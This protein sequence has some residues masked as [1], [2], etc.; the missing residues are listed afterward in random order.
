M[1]TLTVENPNTLSQADLNRLDNVLWDVLS[2][3]SGMG[4]L[5]RCDHCQTLFSKESYFLSR[6]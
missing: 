5:A 3:E 4:E 6:S 2:R 1:L